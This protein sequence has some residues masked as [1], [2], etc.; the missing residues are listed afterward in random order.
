MFVNSSL[1]FFLIQLYQQQGNLIFIL[2]FVM[3]HNKLYQLSGLTLSMLLHEILLLNISKFHRDKTLQTK[4]S[5]NTNSFPCGKHFHLAAVWEKSAVHSLLCA[6]VVICGIT[7]QCDSVVQ[8]VW[9]IP[10]AW[11][12]HITFRCGPV[13]RNTLTHSWHADGICWYATSYVL[14]I[15]SSFL[16][17]YFKLFY[18]TFH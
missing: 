13:Y 7:M 2:R 11:R 18:L 12:P 3:L 10:S 9:H 17:F 15:F 6:A 5:L 16:L 8:I 1:W 14:F 4:R